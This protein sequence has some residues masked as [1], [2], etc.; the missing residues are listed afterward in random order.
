MCT[1]HTD[2]TD[3]LEILETKCRQA[4]V[5]EIEAVIYPRA[6]QGIQDCLESNEIDIVVGPGDCSICVLA[7]LGKCPSAMVPYTL[8]TGEKGMGQPQ[9]LMI[10]TKAGDEGKMLEFMKLWE[11]QIGPWQTAT[12]LKTLR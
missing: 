1:A 2:Q 3:L 7:S 4:D 12:R 8:L 9:G 5:D 11:A 10:I 6:K